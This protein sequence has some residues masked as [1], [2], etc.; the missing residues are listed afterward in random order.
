MMLAI[1]R[2][3][4]RLSVHCEHERSVG[5]NVVNGPTGDSIDLSLAQS[6]LRKQ[7]LGYTL[8]STSMA[9]HQHPGDGPEARFQFGQFDC[10]LKKETDMSAASHSTAN[11][12][13]IRK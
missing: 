8:D 10:R 13:F 3:G 1:A 12:K 2:G 6:A 9:T 11:F 5:D 4:A 7:R